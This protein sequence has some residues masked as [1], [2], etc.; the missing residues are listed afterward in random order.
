MPEFE[1]DPEKARTNR[2]KH[3]IDFTV[4]ALVWSDP[5]HRILQDRHSD[6]EE[7]WQ[8]IG[9][10]GSVTLLIVAHTYRGERGSKVRIISARKATRKE[11]LDHER[12][13]N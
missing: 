1:W 6:G 4:A 3:G 5:L 10:V 9:V 2:Q 8:A 11:R 7:R 12:G 13:N